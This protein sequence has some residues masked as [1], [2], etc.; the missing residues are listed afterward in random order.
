MCG[1]GKIRNGTIAVGGRVTRGTALAGFVFWLSVYPAGHLDAAPPHEE[2]GAEV[3]LSLAE[4]R[5]AGVETERVGRRALGE[6]RRLPAEVTID[7][8]RSARVTPRIPA[9]VVARHVRLGDAVI[10]G[11]RLVT[12]SSVEM[13]EA[14][15]QLIVT[16][17]AWRLVQELGEQAVSSRRYTEAEVSR[18]QA[19]A[20]VMA[21]GMAEGQ[22]GNLLRSG[23]VSS[24]VGAF[25]LTSP[26]AG[27]IVSDNFMS[28][29]LIEPGRILFDIVDE[30]V[31]WVDART[32][33]GGLPDVEPG[34]SVRVFAQDAWLIGQVVGQHHHLDETT[35][36]QGLRVEVAN[37][38]H[39]L[40]PGQFVEVEVTLGA[41][42]MTL[43]VPNTAVTLIDGA[44]SVFVV[45]D[46]GAFYPQAVA[47]GVRT[48]AW[49]AIEDGL[50]TG[51]EVAVSGVFHLKSLLQKASLGEGH[52]H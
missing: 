24:A 33:G 51:D 41:D 45:D 50:S 25:D 43:A 29:E 21:Y 28:G 14:Q 8:Y 52:G 17:R 31:V 7:A 38:D 42:R 46:E 48:G 5:Q 2:A 30:S 40:H 1:C 15:G 19:A 23:D 18:Q 3:E 27:T 44:Q 49:T 4:R 11:Q 32:G 36:T 9:Q 6:T 47:V 39:F 34:M 20:R 37:A 10:A 35:R 26:Q 13:A 16:D 22:V 12:L